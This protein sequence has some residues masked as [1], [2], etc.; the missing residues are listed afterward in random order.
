MDTNLKTKKIRDLAKMIVED[1]KSQ[2]QRIPAA[3]AP[4][5]G[6]MLDLD[7]I[8]QRHGDEPARAVVR[9]ALAYLESWH[10][11]AAAKIKAELRIRLKSKP[12]LN[13]SA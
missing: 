6:A 5:L 11:A 10:G 1:L 2:G 4:S 9:R 3:A 12:G 8:D 7:S 13:H